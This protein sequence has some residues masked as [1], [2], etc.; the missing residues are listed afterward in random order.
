[1]EICKTRI[2][3][4]FTTNVHYSS[5]PTPRQITFF[6]VVPVE[7]AAYSDGRWEATQ[8]KLYEWMVQQAGGFWLIAPADEYGLSEE[9]DIMLF[10]TF[11]G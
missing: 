8:S 7:I 6:F 9:N 4:Q 11:W 10:R 3:R 2:A 1:M 5:S